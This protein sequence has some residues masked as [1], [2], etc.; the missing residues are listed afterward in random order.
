M[1]GDRTAQLL[2]RK[3]WLHLP[4]PVIHDNLARV[5]RGIGVSAS[6]HDSE[7]IR[8]TSQASGIKSVNVL[9]AGRTISDHYGGVAT[10]CPLNSC[11]Q[12]HNFH[13]PSESIS[14]ASPRD[15]VW[16]L[17]MDGVNMRAT[18]VALFPGY[19]MP[20]TPLFSTVY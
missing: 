11:K 6:S 2:S 12:K 13:F 14:G 15:I 17:A 8:V 5:T 4:V 10:T 16:C 9:S 19:Q 20:S 18:V 1:Q 7:G 3:I